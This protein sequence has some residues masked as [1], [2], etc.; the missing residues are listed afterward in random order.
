[1]TK[2]WGSTVFVGDALEL[3]VSRYSSSS[4]MK[5]D[6]LHE[7]P[8]HLDARSVYAPP[9][10]HSEEGRSSARPLI[11]ASTF[12]FELMDIFDAAC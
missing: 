1:M 8:A 7:K 6:D 4:S 10:T 2:S 12:R 9:M 5:M 11:S 3:R